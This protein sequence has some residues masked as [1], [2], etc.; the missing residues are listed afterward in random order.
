MF[1]IVA[2]GE[3]LID[4]APSGRN[5]MGNPLYC[6]NPGGAPANVL[7]MASILGSKTSFIGKVGDDSF[8]HFLKKAIE[9]AG[10]D[11]KGLIVSRK[12][13][14]TLAFVSLSETGD[15]SFSF[16]RDR[17][18]DVMLEEKEID[19]SILKGTKIFHF[20]SVSM[21]AEPSLSAT[22]YA[23]KKAKEYGST[24]S[25]DP[26]YRPLL[27]KCREEAKEIIT[28]AVGMCDI[29]KVSDE[30]LLLITDTSDLR[31]GSEILKSM[32]PKIVIVTMGEN[33]SYIRTDDYEKKYDA[34]K[35]PVVDTTGAGDAFVGAVLNSLLKLDIL[36]GKTLSLQP[37]AWDDIMRF[38]NAAG[39]LTTT[40][41]GAIPA[42]PGKEKIDSFIKP[43][44]ED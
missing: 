6:Q 33:G 16:Y 10:V 29:L 37:S 13:N 7:A 8:G 35:V 21:T 20:G 30:E 19:E 12:Q 39:S 31:K 42:M 9:N 26:N 28:K 1:D 18:A 43:N 15:R 27:W 2:I 23:V 17:T 38:C 14:T 3:A 4:F 40:Q 24:I 22:L 44:I 34:Y 25:F 5:E 32:G 11:T 41:K 36:T